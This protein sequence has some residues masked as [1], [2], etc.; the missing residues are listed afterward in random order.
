MFWTSLSVSYLKM[1]GF[2]YISNWTKAVL[3]L[4]SDKCRPK[5]VFTISLRGAEELTWT[6]SDEKLLSEQR[7]KTAYSY[8][9]SRCMGALSVSSYH[10]SGFKAQAGKQYSMSEEGVE[11]WPYVELGEA[12]GGSIGKYFIRAWNN[13]FQMKTYISPWRWGSTICACVLI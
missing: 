11:Q 5:L 1:M 4:C 2:Y 13:A 12:A 9:S 8:K 7:H 10:M 6:L 3:K